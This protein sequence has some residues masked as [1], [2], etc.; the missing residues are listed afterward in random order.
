MHLKFFI[1]ISMFIII[2]N[3]L[4]LITAL[5]IRNKTLLI[6]SLII[7][8]S[9]VIILIILDLFQNVGDYLI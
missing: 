3:L 6:T 2:L 9:I 8:Q 4:S 1:M 5:Y 7:L